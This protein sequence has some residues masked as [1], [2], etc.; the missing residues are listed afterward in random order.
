MEK[1]YT[2]GTEPTILPHVRC[3]SGPCEQGRKPCPAPDACEIRNDDGRE[4]EFL[5]GV[6]VVITILMVLVL[7]LV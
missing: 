1:H 6:V 5:G 7:V 3:C 4:I 2:D